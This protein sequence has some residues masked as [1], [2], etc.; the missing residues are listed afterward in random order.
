MMMVMIM[1]MMMM[2]MMMMVM[3]SPSYMSAVS[4]AGVPLVHLRPAQVRLD[5]QRMLASHLPSSSNLYRK[6]Q[7]GYY[8]VLFLNKTSN[9][10]ILFIA[11]FSIG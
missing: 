6:P 3:R 10:F 4:R 9:N 2:M 5:L 11:A 1:M 8:V 7:V